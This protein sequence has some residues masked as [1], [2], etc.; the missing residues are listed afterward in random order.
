MKKY[1]ILTLFGLVL[2]SCSSGGGDEVGPDP[3]PDPGP[4][5]EAP[6]V[7]GLTEPTD[8]QICIDNNLTFT[9]GTSTDPESDAVKYTMEI[10]KNMEF[11]QITHSF[12]NLTSNTKTVL[13]EKDLVYY[14]RVKAVD[15]KN[16]SSNFSSIFQFYTE[17]FGEDNHIPFA[18]SLL[19]P[20]LNETISV[21]SVFLSWGATDV[22]GDALTFDIY[23]DTNNPP[24]TIVENDHTDKEYTASS[25]MASTTYYWKIVAKDGNG[26]SSVGQVWSFSTQ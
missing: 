4:V 16:A 21:T 5:N 24:T 15:S 2:M 1:I 20:D 13:L 18:P 3:D 17:G 25:L 12:P 10:S 22:D 6:S 23:L 19:T 8:N 14:W 7:P 9:W 11:T 26:A